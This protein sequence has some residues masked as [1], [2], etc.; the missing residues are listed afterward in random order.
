MKL[1]CIGDDFTGS[2]DLAN[3]LAKEGMRV[4]QF[5]GTPSEDASP[6][7][8]AGVVALKSRTLPAEDAVRL[9]L[10]ALEWLKAQGCTQFFFKYCYTFDSTREGNVGPV[11]D[12]L[13]EALGADRTIV[14]P[15]FPAT[16]R[17]LYQGHLFVNGVL[18]S[19][20]GMEN[21]PLTPMTDADIRRWMGHQTKHAVGHVAATTV[22]EGA[23][24]IRAAIGEE[25]A[26]GRPV[27][28][29]DAIRDA[30]LR[31]IGRAVK[32]MTLITGGSGVS[33]G[34][35]ANLLDKS[36]RIDVAADWSGLEGPAAII[37]GSA[38]K[39]TRA[40]VERY[41]ASNPAME[42]TA[43]M[44]MEGETSPEEAARFAFEADGTALLYS[45]ADPGTV[46]AAQARYGRET[47]AGRLEDFF[48]ETARQ[49]VAGGVTRLVTAGGETS[50]AV[51]EGLDLSALRIGPEIAPG[52]PAVKAE[53]RDLVLALKSGNFGDADFFETALRVLGGKP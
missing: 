30:D 17:S 49:L 14:C 5:T 28:V 11:T 29:V 10:E 47:V 43:E 37:A 1:G 36:D 16:G 19:E 26:A 48:A 13:M 18:L 15:A 6:D 51:V 35:P 44:V 33:L 53:D 52:V 38:S 32:D 21:H 2:S 39:M 40:Q 20:S 42:I 4:T 45:S 12:A 24:A 9:S 34:I 27:I 31:E 41:A 23:D 50:G 3:M 22:F 25:V 8:D 7:V 46:K